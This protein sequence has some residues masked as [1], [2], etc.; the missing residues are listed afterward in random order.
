MNI[1][2]EIKLPVDQEALLVARLAVS[3]AL[4]ALAPYDSWSHEGD[5]AQMAVYVVKTA[6]KNGNLG[7]VETVMGL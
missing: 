6:K 2:E 4:L 1:N 3:F 5:P 7:F